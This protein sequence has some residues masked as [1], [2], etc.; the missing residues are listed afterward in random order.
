[1]HP[2]R[3]LGHPELWLPAWERPTAIFRGCTARFVNSPSLELAWE[4]HG[5]LIDSNAAVVF[6]C[7]FGDDVTHDVEYVGACLA[8]ETL[9]SLDEWRCSSAEG[10]I[11]ADLQACFAP[12]VPHS[13]RM[14]FVAC[15]G[16]VVQWGKPALIVF[17]SELDQNYAPARACDST[18]VTDCIR[19]GR[20]LNIAHY[21]LGE[22]EEKLPPLLENSPPQKQPRRTMTEKDAAKLRIREYPNAGL[23][24]KN[25]RLY[26]SH[27]EEYLVAKKTD[28]VRGHLQTKKHAA[29][30]ETN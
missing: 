24:I 2:Q 11:F 12:N 7:A 27:C 29:S 3:V 23:R 18:F 22:E 8:A 10:A 1:M 9:L 26:C 30:K 19:Y 5:G 16:V 20:L 6:G 25:D 15:G 28:R 14:A 21:L 4:R 13:A 17:T